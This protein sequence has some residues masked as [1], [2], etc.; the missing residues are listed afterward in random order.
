MI[1]GRF[2]PTDVVLALFGVLLGMAA[3]VG[4]AAWYGFGRTGGDRWQDFGGALLF[5]GT[6]VIVAVAAIVWL[7]WKANID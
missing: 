1:K 4:Y 7:G 5:P 6:V 3:A 2:P